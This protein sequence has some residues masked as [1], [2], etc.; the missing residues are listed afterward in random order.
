MRH[1]VYR[2][3]SAK[4]APGPARSGARRLGLRIFAATL[5][6]AVIAAALLLGGCAEEKKTIDL[7]RIPM[8]EGGTVYTVAVVDGP[9]QLDVVAPSHAGL[10]VHR[11]DSGPWQLIEPRSGPAATGAAVAP[12]GPA[13]TLSPAGGAL[14]F[15]P[16]ELFTAHDSRL[17]VAPQASDTGAGRLMVS[18]D[19]GQTWKWVR[20]PA[21]KGPDGEGAGDDGDESGDS[22]M[23]ESPAVDSDAAEDIA[24]ENN[25]A[26]QDESIPGEGSDSPDTAPSEDAA[27]AV[28]ITP[29]PA[30]LHF[31]NAGDLGFYLMGSSNLWRLDAEPGDS[32]G[33]LPPDVEIWERVSL[34][35][36]EVDETDSQTMLPRVLRH[37]LPSTQARPFELLT[38]LRDRL[39]IY[40]RDASEAA[41]EEVAV[42]DG[43]DYQLTGVTGSNLV[44]LLTSEGLYKS[45]DAGES[46]ARLSWYAL[47]QEEAHGIAVEVLA[48]TETEPTVLL[49]ALETGAI[50]RSED[51]GENFIEVRPP[52]V[53]RRVVTG[54]GYSAR[55]NRVWAA[56][57]GS[58]VLRSLDRGR[59][60]HQI[61]DELRATR[62]FDIGVDDSDGFLLGSD[63]GLY[64]LSGTPRE[65]RWQMLQHRATTAIYVEKESGAI[66]NGTATGA[67]VRLEPNGKSTAAQA[68]PFVRNDEVAYQANRFRGRE[69]R[70]QAIVEIDARPD[71]SQVFAWSARRGP[72]VS[73][74]SGVSWT[75]M[76]LNPAFQNAL[77]GSYIS[78]F[79]TDFGERMYLV[80]HGLA[81]AAPT[82]L[83]R[84]YN[85]GGTWHAVSSFQRGPQRHDVFIA[86]SAAYPPETIFMA[87]GNRFARS[88]DGGSSWRDLNGPWND[89]RILL[90][91]LLDTTHLIVVESYQTTQLVRVTETDQER[92]AVQ[93][94]TFNWPEEDAINHGEIRNIA[95]QSGYVFL[96]TDQGL[97]TGALPD[98]RQRLPNGLAILATL[99]SVAV[100][101]LLGFGILRTTI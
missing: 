49:V 17:W 86:R 87:H 48:P 36:A 30:H 78:N 12:G 96:G 76:Q 51:L 41:F 39:Y 19:L 20:L 13:R 6:G 15:R 97:L 88:V 2:P 10:F 65:G 101:T 4:A 7:E 62:T 29:N 60:W 8:P 92:P 53:D 28:R 58:G 16:A 72:M 31:I 94:Y 84:S 64:R 89:G 99:I 40:R 90:Y 68:A 47:S 37:Y 27:P 23:E 55:R 5:L 71:N 69:L 32:L 83:W 45:A 95:V 80:T 1:S 56:T 43:A 21:I 14:N 63:A 44:M 75:P 67:I 11:N 50:Y 77:T 38:V 57:N 18:E 59:T 70:P 61:N 100:L 35:G 81:E 33:A 25:A 26:E 3:A 82:Q 34:E 22:A 98:G 66:L 79:T 91:D 9:E 54:F 42:L 24:S 73:L 93:T 52:D 85:N 46:W 74:D